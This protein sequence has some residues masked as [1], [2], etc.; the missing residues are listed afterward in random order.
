MIFI[1][2]KINVLPNQRNA[3][4]KKILATIA[5]TKKESGCINY[6]IHT[7]LTN[8]NCYTILE[9]WENRADVIKYIKSKTFGD[10]LGINNYL[11]R[12]FKIDIY[13][14]QIEEGEETVK[15]IRNIRSNLY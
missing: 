1:R 4:E 7:E 14:I 13:T 6:S 3:F 10:L 12:P 2:L 15:T 11:E 5:P 8:Q 9:E